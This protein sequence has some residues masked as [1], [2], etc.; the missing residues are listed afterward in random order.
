MKYNYILL[1]GL[2]YWLYS[3][4]NKRQES[5]AAF[6]NGADYNDIYKSQWWA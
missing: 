1:A 3:Q 2:A 5:T 6:L 4:K